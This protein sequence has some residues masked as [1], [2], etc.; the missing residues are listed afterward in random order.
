MTN[1]STGRKRSQKF[2]AGF[3]EPPRSLP[4]PPLSGKERERSNISS[5]LINVTCMIVVRG[6]LDTVGDNENWPQVGRQIGA[7]SGEVFYGRSV[8]SRTAEGR[9]GRRT[10]DGRKFLLIF[11][12]AH[13]R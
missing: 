3:Q 11:R 1:V 10:A 13:L 12:T 8:G 7:M 9:V 6:F 4:P 2:S 5:Y